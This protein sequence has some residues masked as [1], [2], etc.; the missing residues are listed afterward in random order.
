MLINITLSCFQYNSVSN[1]T[2]QNTHTHTHT[3]I[4]P[5]AYSD[6]SVH[7]SHH[8]LHFLLF[9][10][11]L[12][13]QHSPC[14]S[15]PTSIKDIHTW[16]QEHLNSL[17]SISICIFINGLFQSG[18]GMVIVQY[19]YYWCPIPS[20]IWL[21]SVPLV[22]SHPKCLNKSYPSHIIHNVISESVNVHMTSVTWKTIHK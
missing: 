5:I 10:S 11:L 2:P 6:M 1:P 9:V 22:P 7:R 3:H 19:T 8:T 12:H 17:Y 14:M 18:S 4:F 16:Y 15:N 20:P 13:T 21:L